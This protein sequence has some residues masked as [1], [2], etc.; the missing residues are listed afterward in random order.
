M[1]TLIIDTTS[2][3]L[4]AILQQD[5]TIIAEEKLIGF[6]HSCKLNLAIET[7]LSKSGNS[8]QG[9]D[10]F[11]VCIGVGSFT[12]IRVG[13]ATVKGFTTVFPDKKVISFNS[14]QALAYTKS[15]SIDCLY[16]AGRELYYYARYNRLIEEISPC[17]IEKKDAEG[18]LERGALLFDSQADYSQQLNE[19]TYDLICHKRFCER[20]S[21]IYLRQPQA[22]EELLKNDK[23]T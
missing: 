2:P 8:L 13:I 7:L 19:L 21:P 14:L 4:Y 1:K 6:E 16:D 17:L 18:L 20:L 15:G 3:R 5:G 11:G 22:V 12:G 23:R 9:L 10:C